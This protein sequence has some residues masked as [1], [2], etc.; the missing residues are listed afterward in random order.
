[1]LASASSDQ[2]VRLWD[3]RSGQLQRVLRGHATGVYAVCFSADGERLATGS[4][5]Q[6]VRI[7]DIRTGQQ[8]LSLRGHTH[9]VWGVS[10][11]PDGR[12]LASCSGDGTVRIWDA[13]PPRSFREFSGHTEALTCLC[14]SPDGCRLATASMDNTLRL[15]DVASGR[16]LQLLDSYTTPPHTM[17]FS[18]DGKRLLGR[19][20]DF[21][22]HTWDVASGKRTAGGPTPPLYDSLVALSPDG[23]WVAV[24]RG[25]IVR[26]FDGRLSA[27]EEA[28]RRAATAADPGW[29][30]QQAEQAAR[31]GQWSAV[32]FHLR[33]LVADRPA[34]AGLQRQLALAEL[35]Q[36]GVA[37]AIL[38]DGHMPRAEE[39][40]DTAA[41][42]AYRDVCGRLLREF[43]TAPESAR[44]CVLLP[45]FPDPAR[46][47]PLVE[48]ADPVT[49][50]AILC[51]AGRYDE[52]VQVLQGKPYPLAPL[53]QALAEQGRGRPAE[54]KK[55]LGL[56]DRWLASRFGYSP[57]ETNLAHLPWPERVETGVL[58]REVEAILD[59]AGP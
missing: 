40:E 3:A 44:A 55:L 38:G 14:F 18:A 53:Y 22:V 15:W 37:G 49:R 34:D 1:L 7:W 28:W 21:T 35:A 19:C 58:L 43:A 9:S 29:D 48:G 12:R 10:F 26:V 27:A 32:V 31:A 54:A 33:R 17:S 24:A 8:L 13:R 20:F 57:G 46:L 25:S 36:A 11:S 41:R 30:V 5:D 16:Q 6:T 2:T 23:H 39:P 50:G 59:K 47:L 42:A 45:D 51:R 4:T 52:A 56:V